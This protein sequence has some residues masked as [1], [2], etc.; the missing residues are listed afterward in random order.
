MAEKVITG[1]VR[2][3]YAHVFEPH[4]VEEGQE[5]K[6]SVAL[7]ID[8]KDTATIEKINRAVEAAIEDGKS[9]FGGKIP[10]NLKRPLRDGT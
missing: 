5:K 3:S 2:F 8:K 4:S 1:K 7:L 9:V 6:F 10:A